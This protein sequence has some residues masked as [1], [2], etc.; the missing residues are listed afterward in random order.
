MPTIPIGL[1]ASPRRCDRHTSEGRN[2][3]ERS[4]S[5]TNACRERAANVSNRRSPIGSECRPCPLGQRRIR[6]HELRRVHNQGRCQTGRGFDC[7]RFSRHKQLG[8][9]VRKDKSKS[10][11]SGLGIAVF[12]QPAGGRTGAGEGRVAKK[13]RRSKAVL[14]W[15]EG[16]N[17]LSIGSRLTVQI[18]AAISSDS[19]GDGQSRTNPGVA[20]QS[21]EIKY[22]KEHRRP[23]RAGSTHA[24]L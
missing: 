9:C 10:L 2:R 20:K 13:T 19:G 14:G 8:Q 3:L 22:P 17:G 5:A 7:D 18:L 15:R 11:G 6:L 4:E 1:R 12:P 16:R 23:A 24:V 21:C